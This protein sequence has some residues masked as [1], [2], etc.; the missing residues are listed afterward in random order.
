MM[1]LLVELKLECER[2]LNSRLYAERTE[3]CPEGEAA[4]MVARI[5]ILEV[6]RKA[7]EKMKAAKSFDPQVPS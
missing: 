2:V 5:Q 3:K 7:E 1:G 4:V 6:F